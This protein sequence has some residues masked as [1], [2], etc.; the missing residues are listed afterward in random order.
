MVTGAFFRLVLAAGF[1]AFSSLAV[2]HLWTINPAPPNTGIPGYNFPAIQG[3]QHIEDQVFDRSAGESP[4][5]YVKR[6][7]DLVHLSTYNCLSDSYQLSLLERLVTKIVSSRAIF[8][9][10]ILVKDRFSCGLC[11]QRAFVVRRFLQANG[12]ATSVYGLGGHVVDRITIDGTEYASDPDYG[13]GPF[14]LQPNSLDGV[15][16]ATYS[17]A[18]WANIDLLTEI[19]TSLSDNEAYGSYIDDKYRE[20]VKIFS[21]ANWL[22]YLCVILSAAIA[23]L[24]YIEMKSRIKK[25]PIVDRKS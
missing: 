22:F 24:I 17:T 8:S 2:E 20:Q 7:T 15:I 1:M 14:P 3:L 4:L 25:Y 6:V 11:H 21:I 13:V 16:R 5:G 23:V 18:P 19:F 10:G 12:I 9:E